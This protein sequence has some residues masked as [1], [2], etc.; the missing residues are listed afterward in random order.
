M[1]Q[2]NSAKGSHDDV[3]TEISGQLGI[4]TLNRP[5]ALNALTLDMIRTITATLK[6][7]ERNEKVRHVMFVGA[8]ERAFCAGGDLKTCYKVGMEYRRGHTN[9]K[10]PCLFFAEEYQFN[11]YLWNYSKPLIS[12]MNGI[13]MGGGYGVAGNSK[14][15]VVTDKTV[16]AMPEVAIGF[17]PDVGSMYHLP[18]FKGQIGRYL[19]LTGNTIEADDAHY[20]GVGEYYIPSTK[21]VEL[22]QALSN[23]GSVAET[24][25]SFSFDPDS[26]APMDGHADKIASIFAHDKVED[27]LSAL[28]ADGSAWAADIYETMTA[29]RSPASIYVTAEYFRRTQHKSVDEVLDMDFHLAQI[30]VQRPDLYEGI[31]RAVLDKQ[32]KPAWDPARLK[33]IT[34]EHV[35][36]YFRPAA[37]DL[38]DM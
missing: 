10:V 15:R 11:K 28:E 30:F 29:E 3:V 12:F 33:D 37:Y 9:L 38:K 6:V 25:R 18:R 22:I 31:R 8:G 32:Y 7:W 20:A 36:D 14:H 17:F 19:A 13:T 26:D 2:Y 34:D 35:N 27:I 1:N 5:E 23:T 21:K 24:L 16:F 4:I